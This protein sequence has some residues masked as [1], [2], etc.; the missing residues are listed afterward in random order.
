MRSFSGTWIIAVATMK[1][2]IRQP[3]FFLLI[4]ISVILMVLN[5]FLPFFSLG[6]DVKML[7]DCGLATL[8]ISGLLLAVWTASQSI[9]AEIEGKT[10]ITLLSKPITRRQF[11]MGKYI[12]IL[13]GVFIFFV[14]VVLVFLACI[15]YKVPYDFREASEVNYMAAHSWIEIIQVLPGIALIFMEVSILAAISVAIS[16]RLPMVVNMVACLAIFVVGHLTPTLVNS[17]ALQNEL[18]DFFARLIATVLPALEVFNVQ[19]AVA[20]GAPVPGI[21][22]GWSAIYAVAY[23]A[24]AILLAFILFEDRDL[25]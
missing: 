8:L 6:D 19:A 5:T 2:A 23:S 4:A 11:I 13:M 15:Y 9:A 21:Y 25:A 14:P 24:A 17:G 18:V 20:T 1:E 7:K 3:F 12:G 22:L 16:T 10:A